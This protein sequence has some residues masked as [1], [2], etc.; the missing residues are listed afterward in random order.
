MGGEVWVYPHYFVNDNRWKS[1]FL[2]VW[3]A[4]DRCKREGEGGETYSS[5]VG[6]A[7]HSVPP[8][9]SALN[10]KMPATCSPARRSGLFPNQLFLL[11]VVFPLLPLLFVRSIGFRP[12]ETRAKGEDG[13]ELALE[14]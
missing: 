6:N 7:S 2:R 3:L 4:D 11:F 8:S 13:F 10:K 5:S 14:L 12:P 1:V 9:T